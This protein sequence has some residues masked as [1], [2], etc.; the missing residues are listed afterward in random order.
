MIPILALIA[1][2]TLGA[3]FGDATAGAIS[4]DDGMTIEIVVEVDGPF[5]VVIVRPF[6]S[7]EELPPTALSDL[8]NGS[9]GGF[10]TLPTPENWSV[11]FDA[12]DPDGTTYRSDTTDLIA[13]GVDRVLID[14]PPQAPTGGSSWPVATVWLVLAVVLIL[15]SLAALTWWTFS[16]DP[17]PAGP[18][19][20]ALEEEPDAGGDEPVDEPD[21]APDE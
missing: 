19:D 3:P 20:E 7:F 2:V 12:F 8:G 18:D 21:A 4:L 15:G 17:E 11:L 10:V 9:W 14:A 13:L 1:M 16:G 6:S 5:E